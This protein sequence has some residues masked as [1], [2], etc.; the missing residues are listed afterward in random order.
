MAII[1]ETA[2]INH[3]LYR[4]GIEKYFKASSGGNSKKLLVGLMDSEGKLLA[5]SGLQHKISESDANPEN[6]SMT[7]GDWN[8]T[9]G[10]NFDSKTLT[11][12]T[13]HFDNT[14][15]V[16]GDTPLNARFFAVIDATQIA[17]ANLNWI[18]TKIDESQIL[19]PSAL[20]NMISMTYNPDTGSAYFS[21]PELKVLMF[22]SL[23]NTPSIDAS[24]NFY[25]SGATIKFT[26][27]A[28]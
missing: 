21:E 16:V 28:N 11:L 25:F 22:G 13:I 7:L 6:V 12:P 27:A 24:T 5:I 9:E 15:S 3:E 14:A 10:T 17:E 2:F 4:E 19:V 23:S 20:T 8:G 26:E 18:E 1:N